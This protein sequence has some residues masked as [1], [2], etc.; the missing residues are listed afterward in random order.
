[1]G[2]E[3]RWDLFIGTALLLD[4]DPGSRYAITCARPKASRFSSTVSTIAVSNFGNTQLPLSATAAS[5]RLSDASQR[6]EPS[7]DPHADNK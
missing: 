1:M 5:G 4:Y 2:C 7:D 3:W 6:L